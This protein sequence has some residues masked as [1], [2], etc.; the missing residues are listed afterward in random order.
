M[1]GRCIAVNAN[2]A[3][4][5]ERDKT[6]LDD[7]I[8]NIIMAEKRIFSDYAGR[9]VKSYFENNELDE[10][11]GYMLVFDLRE[12]PI[13]AFIKH[14]LSDWSYDSE[15]IG[16]CRSRG[17]LTCC[18]ISAFYNGDKQDDGEPQELILHRTIPS[19]RVLEALSRSVLTKA[20]LLLDR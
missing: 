17:L 4:N 11:Y 10:I 2:T 7:I 1:E 20:K 12:F 14:S 9:A 15:W 16:K 19:G 3:V 5:N 13:R 6:K 18:F 8:G